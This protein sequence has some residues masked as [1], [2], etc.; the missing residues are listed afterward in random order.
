[1]TPSQIYSDIRGLYTSLLDNYMDMLDERSDG[2]L[3]T[4]M[5]EALYEY[6][7]PYGDTYNYLRL[8]FTRAYIQ[9]ITKSGLPMTRKEVDKYMGFLRMVM[10][11]T[12]KTGNGS[13]EL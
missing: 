13:T 12:V 8:N 5:D 11:L 2:T 6:E 10:A 4:F 7:L 3:L 1:M 9:E